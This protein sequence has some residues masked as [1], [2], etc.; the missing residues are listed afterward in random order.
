[1]SQAQTCFVPAATK[2]LQENETG[3]RPCWFRTDFTRACPTLVRAASSAHPKAAAMGATTSVI[4]AQYL[5]AVSK[6][7]LAV[8][9][10]S[11][12]SLVAGACA[13]LLGAA[14]LLLS[15][16]RRLRH[17]PSAATTAMIKGA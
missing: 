7:S 15:P 17:Y 16:L 11:C 2:E 6:V 13:G 5:S 3:P 9:S 10:T 4:N 12:V 14:W 8:T 1:M